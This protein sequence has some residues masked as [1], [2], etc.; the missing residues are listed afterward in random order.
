MFPS[1]TSSQS[2]S[3]AVLRLKHLF[4]AIGFRAGHDNEV[5]IEMTGE[6]RGELVRYFQSVGVP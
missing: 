6:L 1:A 3:G 2:V 4:A 5:V